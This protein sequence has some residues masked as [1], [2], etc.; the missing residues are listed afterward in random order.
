MVNVFHQFQELKDPDSDL[1][2]YLS[3][4]IC[5][6]SNLFLY[7][8]FGKQAN[9]SFEK[10]ADVFYDCNWQSL[11][12]RLQ[13]NFIVA[14]ANTQIPIYYHGFGVAF[15]TLETFTN[16]SFIVKLIFTANSIYFA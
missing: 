8:Y 10:M 9:Y 15:L 16:V 14:L 12:Y 5:G 7:C 4:A 2:I 1:M 6:T 11:P 13:K 3:A